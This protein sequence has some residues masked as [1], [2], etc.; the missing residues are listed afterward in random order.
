[1]VSS[2]ML[3]SSEGFEAYQ[4]TET[5]SKGFILFEVKR[6]LDMKGN[7]IM[8]FIAVVSV[9]C[10][11][12]LRSYRKTALDFLESLQLLTLTR[13]EEVRYHINHFRSK[14]RSIS[15]CLIRRMLL[16]GSR[17]REAA[18]VYIALL[19][20][21]HI[22]IPHKRILQDESNRVE[23]CNGRE[24]ESSFHSYDDAIS[25]LIWLLRHP[26]ARFFG[27]S[28]ERVIKEY[29]DI[30]LTAFLS[31]LNERYYSFDKHLEDSLIEDVSLLFSE[32]FSEDLLAITNR[33]LIKVRDI[34]IVYR[35]CPI[36]CSLNYAGERF[37]W[38]LLK[39]LVSTLFFHLDNAFPTTD[40][41]SVTRIL[42][43]TDDFTTEPVFEALYEMIGEY[44]F[45]RQREVILKEG[46]LKFISGFI[47]TPNPAVRIAVIHLLFVA[48][49]MIDDEHP[50][51][52]VTRLLS[53]YIQDETDIRVKNFYKSMIESR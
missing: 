15:D 11:S 2:K 5:D 10:Q 28:R 32:N 7:L 34:E 22:L 45:G 37:S 13:S 12:P 18:F 43:A 16:G 24:Q 25:Y 41:S 42:E 27:D 51:P 53:P 4:G 23:W 6:R 9:G 33:F 40:R 17:C 35:Y 26:N 52:L 38:K 14:H 44:V 48:G 31:S 39:P 49:S 8:V 21:E 1:M 46:V 3:S 30:A 19:E 50:S 29:T 36:L 20:R 47:K